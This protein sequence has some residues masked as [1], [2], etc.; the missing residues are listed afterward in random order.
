[1]KKISKKAKKTMRNTKK[2][3]YMLLM[4]SVILNI[5]NVIK[6]IYSEGTNTIA[7]IVVGVLI[8]IYQLY[9]FRSIMKRKRESID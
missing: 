6:G 1:M 2:W 9:V 3:S 4:I 7:I 8:G 5:I